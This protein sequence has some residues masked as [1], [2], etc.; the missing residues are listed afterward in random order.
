M[1]TSQRRPVKTNSWWKG[2]NVH[3]ILI[4]AVVGLFCKLW[5]NS[6]L[7]WLNENLYLKLHLDHIFQISFIQKKAKK[8]TEKI[9]RTSSKCKLK[10]KSGMSRFISHQALDPDRNWTHPWDQQI[11][12]FCP[13]TFCWNLIIK[14]KLHTCC[15]RNKN[16]WNLWG[17][18]LLCRIK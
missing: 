3:M 8:D 1:Q 10:Q 16:L 5:D 9:T 12:F 4:P 11:D 2:L 7:A 14:C 18:Q 6:S 15:C 17:H 13:E